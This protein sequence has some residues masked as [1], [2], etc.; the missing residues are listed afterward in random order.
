MTNTII[1]GHATAIQVE[2]SGNSLLQNEV[3]LGFTIWYDNTTKTNGAGTISNHDQFDVNPEYT[4][5]GTQPTDMTPYHIKTN[6]YAVNRGTE[7]SLTLPGT[8]LLLDIDGQM[9]PSGSGMDIGADEVVTDPLSVWFV[10]AAI[11]STVKAGTVVTNIHNLL[12]SGTQ[13]DTYDISVSN[14]LWTGSVS[15]ATVSLASQS[16]TSVTVTITVPAGAADGVTNLTTLKA[17]SQAESNHLAMAVD[18]T[19]VSTNAGKSKIHYVW[20]NSPGPQAPYATPDSA[21]HEIQTVVDV[22]QDGDTVLVYPG[23]YNSGGRA[24]PARSLTNR[25][26]ITNNITLTSTSGRDSTIIMGVANPVST[27]GPGA[28]RGVYLDGECLFSGFTVID[29]HT[30]TNNLVND[31]DLYGGGIYFINN[32]VVSNC[33]IKACS[34]E[35]HGG[36][37]FGNNSAAIY[38]SDIL[39]NDAHAFAGGVALSNSSET[40]N[41]LIEYNRCDNYGGG[42]M[43]WQSF[44]Y[45]CTVISNKGWKGGGFYCDADSIFTH[46]IVKNN[47]SD[48]GGGAFCDKKSLTEN[49]L[50]SENNATYGGGIRANSNS[51]I[52]N[53]TV[54]DNTATSGDG[55]YCNKG[56]V[57]EN[58][59]IYLNG[60]ENWTDDGYA[61]ITLSNCCTTPLPASGQG[62]ISNMPLFVNASSGD[63]HIKTNSPCIDA[64]GQASLTHQTD[65]DGKHRPMDGN[66]DGKSIL[67]IGCYEI[68]NL[69]GDSDEDGASDSAE[70]IADTN[71]YDP[72][73]VFKITAITNGTAVHVFFDSSTTRQYILQT[74]TNLISG[75]WTNVPGTS[76]HLG[77][78]GRD[79]MS[80]TNQPP[81]GPYYR[82]QVTQ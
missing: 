55:I 13:N 81:K 1:S 57:I 43:L 72:D 42:L 79:S 63:W 60:T 30:L 45:N 31:E 14:T 23:T 26:C 2:D 29:G 39:A 20:Q 6:S 35:L 44:A 17:V 48:L 28:V 3:E 49:T 53:C 36:G 56:T 78:G 40:H 52:R 37:V 68:Q 38:N 69:N 11:S 9:R 12:N 16:Y 66:A 7:I 47:T 8:D 18:T 62:N 50:F 34:S 25:V 54:V 77:T 59:I 71:P 4:G 15:P 58:S 5:T 10:P 65:L 32:A 61:P 19:G 22:C 76:L 70:G 41:T 75:S 21:G 33:I 73:D 74:R 80:D 64:A 51:T 67:D 46:G 27:N 24:A 82:L